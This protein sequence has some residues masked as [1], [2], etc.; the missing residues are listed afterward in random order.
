MLFRSTDEWLPGVV[1]AEVDG[2]TRV[3]TMADGSEIKEEI[4]DYEPERRSF[5][6]RHLQVPMP[7]ADSGGSF[8]VEANPTRVVL[9]SCFTPHDPAVGGM[10]DGA[11]QQALDSLKRRVEEGARWDAA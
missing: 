10:I 4:S 3:C 5:R 8:V 11:F 7:I 2:P 1:K 9:E 6:F